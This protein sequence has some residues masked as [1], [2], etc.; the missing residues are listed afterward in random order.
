[1]KSWSKVLDTRFDDLFQVKQ[2]FFRHFSETNIFYVSKEFAQVMMGRQQKPVRWKVCVPAAVSSFDMAA[3]ALYVKEYFKQE[4]KTEAVSMI[5]YIQE[6]FRELVNQLEWMDD[7]TKVI[8]IE[9]VKC[10]L[11]VIFSIRKTFL[12][13]NYSG[14]LKFLGWN[15]VKSHWL[16]R[17]YIK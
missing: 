6:A 14:N 5:K 4:D 1:M 7:V 15:Y 3:G 17:V 13:I 10:F 2:T 8:A 9:K 16:P 11:P 12:K